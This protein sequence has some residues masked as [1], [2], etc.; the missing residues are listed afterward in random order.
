MGR[1]IISDINVF[2]DKETGFSPNYVR[3]AKRIPTEHMNTPLTFKFQYFDTRGL[4][5]DLETFAYGAVFDGD[6]V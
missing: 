5:A 1:F 3:I 4:K 6:N 2:A